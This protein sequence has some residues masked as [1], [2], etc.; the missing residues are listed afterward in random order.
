[1]RQHVT[2]LIV[3]PSASA[4]GAS[5]ATTIERITPPDPAIG[6]ESWLQ[7]IVVNNPMILP[8]D[9]IE[10]AFTGPVTIC[11]ELPVEVGSV[12]VFMVNRW[13]YPIIVE[14]KLWANPEA[15][16][17]V[18]AQALDYARCLANSDVAA[19]EAVVRKRRPEA[20]SIY[21]IVFDGISDAHDRAAFYDALADNLSNGRF[22]ILLVGDG[23]R[24]SVEELT[25]FLRMHAHMDFT[26]G[27]VELPSYRIPES[28]GILVTPRIVARTVA[29]ERATAIPNRGT[30]SRTAAPQTPTRT[31]RT[32]VSEQQFLDM[33]EEN[34]PGL[35]DMLRE[36]ID[37]AKD[38][39]IQI[40]S[41]SSAAGSIQLYWTPQE[42]QTINFG[43]LKGDG[44]WEEGFY[45][46]TGDQMKERYKQQIA[47]LIGG[48]IVQTEK[49]TR[50]RGPDGKP[51]RLRDLLEKRNAWLEIINEHMAHA[52]TK[53]ESAATR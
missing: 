18:V 44:G 12:D 10:P 4:S 33:L 11:S 43:V 19:I 53:L 31:R 48:H 14:T 42:G 32:T 25:E 7:D 52:M 20:T 45:F 35:G 22:L 47:D 38:R 2:P 49:G 13:G 28:D 23:I 36:F 29:I 26:F 30:V 3:H 17:Q 40:R 9:E 41:G 39:E 1:M 16:R 21:D 27:L 6:G 34:E 8:I 51:P 37:E 24:R 5:R 46:F 50:L 15:R